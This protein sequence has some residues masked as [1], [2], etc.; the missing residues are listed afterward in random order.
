MARQSAAWRLTIEGVGVVRGVHAN[1]FLFSIGPQLRT[2]W[3]LLRR[4]RSST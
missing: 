3:P 2:T 4:T 1:L